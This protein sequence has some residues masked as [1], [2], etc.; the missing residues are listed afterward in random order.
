MNRKKVV[1]LRKIEILA[2]VGGVVDESGVTLVVSG[3]DLNPDDVTHLLRVEPTRSF[4]RGY[5]RQLGSRPM[6][7]GAWFLEIRGTSP[8]G[9]EVQ[10]RK[11][12]MKLPSSAGVWKKLRARY[13]V[14]FRFGLHMSGW[15][16]GFGIPA[17][18]V[19]RLETTGGDVNFDIYAYG[20]DEGPER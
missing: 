7:H 5:K 19:R 15:N 20:D 10:L 17:A 11:L 2:E 16:K 1:P 4:K 14:Q 12:L 13:D 3:R 8:K 18:L 9:P 6:P